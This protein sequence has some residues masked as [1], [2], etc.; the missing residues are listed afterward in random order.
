MSSTLIKAGAFKC[1]HRGCRRV[2]ERRNLAQFRRHVETHDPATKRFACPFPGCDHSTRQK[3]NLKTHMKK[4]TN[5]KD[6]VCPNPNCTFATGDPAAILRHRKRVHGYKPRRFAKH[7][8]YADA[9]S[10]Y[11]APPPP[12]ARNVRWTTGSFEAGVA[13]QPLYPAAEALPALS[14]PALDVDGLFPME[15]GYDSWNAPAMKA[16]SDP[17]PYLNG[18]SSWESPSASMNWSMPLD[19][20]FMPTS[21]VAPY[22]SLSGVSYTE[23]SFEQSVFDLTLSEMYPSLFPSPTTSYFAT[24][25]AGMHVSEPSDF[26]YLDG[27]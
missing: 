15:S 27:F 8:R 5:T 25:P 21:S 13:A 12:H 14:Y 18:W 4:H 17:A 3:S 7:V 6:L 19:Q 22:P 2:F 1:H 26:G 24:Q 11:G 9:G 10:E 23:Q 16:E 20:N